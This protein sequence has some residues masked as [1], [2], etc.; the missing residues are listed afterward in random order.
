MVDGLEAKES[1]N[2]FL[3]IGA[4]TVGRFVMICY[5]LRKVACCTSPQLKPCPFLSNLIKA[6]VINAKLGMNLRM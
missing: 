1:S 6:E 2:G 4:Y 5:S 3:R